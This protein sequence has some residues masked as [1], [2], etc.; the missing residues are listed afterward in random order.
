MNNRISIHSEEHVISDIPIN[1]KSKLLPINILVFRIG[2]GGVIKNSKPC[3]HCLEFMQQCPKIK[4]YYIKNIY[5]SDENGKIIK[6]SFD[7]LYKKRNEY[8]SSYY[9]YITN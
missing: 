9:K 4:R 8:V 7:D 3:K 2:V 1:K 6:E 5:Y